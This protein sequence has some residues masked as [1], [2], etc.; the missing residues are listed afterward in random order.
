MGG[1]WEEEIDRFC[2]SKIAP[3]VQGIATSMKKVEKNCDRAGQPIA[4]PI[5]SNH[6]RLRTHFEV[7]PSCQSWFGQRMAGIVLFPQLSRE[8]ED[9]ESE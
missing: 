3:Q 5:A 7:G 4:G 2:P 9:F 6:R 1:R 8:V